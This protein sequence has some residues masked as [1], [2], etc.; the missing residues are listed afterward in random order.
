MS[1]AVQH[2]VE[3]AAKF[4]ELKAVCAVLYAADIVRSMTLQYDWA[5]GVEDVAFDR[6]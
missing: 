2:D 1:E 6:E 3:A 5:M 4:G